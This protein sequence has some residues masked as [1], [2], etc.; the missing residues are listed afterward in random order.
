MRSSADSG[1]SDGDAPHGATVA[2]AT[3]AYLVGGDPGAPK[4]RIEIF[5]GGAI[6][7][8]R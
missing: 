8:D 6:G 5:G 7:N 3:I 2:I 4:E 1:R